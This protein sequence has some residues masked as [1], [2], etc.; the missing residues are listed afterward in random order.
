VDSLSTVAPPKKK[1]PWTSPSEVLLWLLF[2]ALVFPAAFAG[3]AVGHYTSLGKPPKTV[4][5]TTTVGSTMSTPET[6]TSAATTTSSSGGDVA[7]GKALFTSANCAGCHTF[8]AANA[9]GTVGP[10]LDDAIAKDA[11]ADGNMD[12]DAFIKESITN[13]D[14]Y[15]AN[16][17][18]GG[19]MPADG[20]SN[21]TPKQIDDLV[22]FISANTQ[23]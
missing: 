22:A 17:F 23:Q 1:N 15:H 8:S 6:T 20:G 5:S 7:A 13:P 4:I 3:Y 2:V 18:S 9:S 14:A 12:L 16:G 11:Q 21:L 19:G 10:N